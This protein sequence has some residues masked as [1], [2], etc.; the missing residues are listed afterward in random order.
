MFG[1]E[2]SEFSSRISEELCLKGGYCIGLIKDG[3]VADVICSGFLDKDKQ[4]SVNK[5]TKFPFSCNTKMLTALLAYNLLDIDIPIS[6]FCKMRFSDNYI[7]NNITLKD[8]LCH[9]SGIYPNTLWTYSI[10]EQDIKDTIDKVPMLKSKSFRDQYIYSNYTYSIIG[11]IMEQFFN[12]EFKD[13]FNAELSDKV[14]IDKFTFYEKDNNSNKNVILAQP[15]FKKKKEYC[16][17]ELLNVYGINPASGLIVNIEEAILVVIYML[18]LSRNGKYKKFFS[19]NIIS[20]NVKYYKESGYEKY[21]LGLYQKEVYGYEIYYHLGYIV[22]YSSFVGFVPEINCGIV[23]LCNNEKSVFPRIVAYKAL[24]M[25]CKI[26][27]VNWKNRLLKEQMWGEYGRG[28]FEKKIMNIDGMRY[29]RKDKIHIN[30]FG[31][32]GEIDFDNMTICINK[33]SFPMLQIGDKQYYTY[34]SDLNDY[35]IL[36]LD[37]RLVMYGTNMIDRLLF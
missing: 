1:A 23:I 32:V 29:T 7:T 3:K 17:G 34:I 33:L 10:L 16:E 2:L 26:E 28:I 6:S 36:T 11:Y 37:D 18:E 31:L 15:F 14:G 21:A 8:L 19:P 4:F 25:Y 9:R 24:E 5:K 12:I 20:N 35:L 13:L 30:K 22:G 27:G